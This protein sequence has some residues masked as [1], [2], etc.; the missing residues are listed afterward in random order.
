[1]CSDIHLCIRKRRIVFD[2]P[3]ALQN[4]LFEVTFKGLLLRS[5]FKKDLVDTFLFLH[6]AHFQGSHF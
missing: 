6:S 4:L 3:T 5:L 1:M 2:T